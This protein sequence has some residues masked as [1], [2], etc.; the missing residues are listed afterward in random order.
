M[1]AHIHMAIGLEVDT[2]FFQQSSLSTPTW[3]ST[4]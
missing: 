4:T 3:S 2:L 1:L